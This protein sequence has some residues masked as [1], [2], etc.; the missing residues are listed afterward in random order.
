MLDFAAKHGVA[1][2]VQVMPMSAV[3]EAL[4]VTRRN[5]ARYRVVLQAGA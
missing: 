2:K 1:A 5:R 4:D 3:N